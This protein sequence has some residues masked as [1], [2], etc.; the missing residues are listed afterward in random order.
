LPPSTTESGMIPQMRASTLQTHRSRIRISGADFEVSRAAV[1]A[2]HVS[3]GFALL[4]DPVVPCGILGYQFLLL[5]F[6]EDDRQREGYSGIGLW[7]VSTG[8][9]GLC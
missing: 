2:M 3:L 7:R 4:G 9:C 6:G 1:E 5:C 8:T